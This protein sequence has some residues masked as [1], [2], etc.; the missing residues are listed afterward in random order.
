[1]TLYQESRKGGGGPVTFERKDYSL[2]AQAIVAA[3]GAGGKPGE[4][5]IV[6]GKASLNIA[7]FCSLVLQEPQGVEVELQPQGK[8]TLTVASTWIKVPGPTP[9][10]RPAP[11]PPP[12]HPTRRR[13]SQETDSRTP[14]RR[15][16]PLTSPHLT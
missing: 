6:F 2:K 11:P 9:P 13:A 10:A 1:M 7:A 15:A 14:L 5:S 3:A 4:K 16:S 8:M 12:H